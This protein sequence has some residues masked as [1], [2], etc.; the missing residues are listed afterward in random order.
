MG[1]PNETYRAS[2][3]LFAPVEDISQNFNAGYPSNMK[4]DEIQGESEGD[5]DERGNDDEII[6]RGER[7]SLLEAQKGLTVFTAA[8]FIIGE[9]A[10]SGVLALP[11]AI[12]GAGWTGIALLIL[13]CFASGYC[14]MVLGRSWTLLRERHEEYR[15][16]VRYPY[17]AIGGEGIWKMG[18][19]RCYCLYSNNST[20]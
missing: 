5:W 18:I 13:C 7:Y 16:H 19:H 4:N 3:Q 14:G 17:P 12:V 10:G 8:V 15:G 2:N 9:M 6:Q 1:D 20:R 11:S